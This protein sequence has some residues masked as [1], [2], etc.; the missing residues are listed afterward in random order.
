MVQKL[1][2]SNISEDFKH[3]LL[4]HLKN[5]LK[6]NFVE[7][8]LFVAV[9]HLFVHVFRTNKTAWLGACSV[10]TWPNNNIIVLLA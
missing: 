9:V 1:G 6:I 4:K 7:T 8:E 2:I 10:R 5:K 3:P